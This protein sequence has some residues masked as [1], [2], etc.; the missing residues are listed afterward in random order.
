MYLILSPT[1]RIV[2]I[3]P[4]AQYVRRQRNKIVVGCAPENAD[5]IY[6]A[7]TDAFY[8]LDPTGYIGDGHTL[9]EVDA[10]PE[11][12]EA[13]Y[14]YY[15]ANEFYTTVDDLARLAQ[16]KIA[17]AA[18][19]AAS[20]AFV[21]LVESEMIDD[22]TAAEHPDLFVPWSENWTGKRGQIVRDEGA[23]Y[24]AI[25]DILVP[26]QNGKPKNS[27]AIW[28]AIG[29]PGEEWPMWSQ[30]IAGVDTPYMKGDK[31]SH[32]GKH[33]TSDIDN[34][35]WAPGAYGWTEVSA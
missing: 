13:G 33:W 27:P 26:A 5:A 24:K 7:N 34:N 9:A 31:A 18:P 35:V 20:I 1:K 11:A 6:S 23:L 30:P 12:V 8:P 29:D 22:I 15:H 16:D 21:K 10:I 17:L 4:Q 14:Y 3:S 2:D 32:N 19:L 28:K 25:H